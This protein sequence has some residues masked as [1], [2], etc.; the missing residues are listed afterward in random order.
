MLLIKLLYTKSSLYAWNSLAD[1]PK[2]LDQ[3]EVK[4]QSSRTV[5]LKRNGPLVPNYSEIHSLVVEVEEPENHTYEI[6]FSN[7]TAVQEADPYL[8]VTGLR[9]FTKYR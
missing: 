1:R 5:M 7:M 9:P 6:P 4:E 2:R 8:T 3:P